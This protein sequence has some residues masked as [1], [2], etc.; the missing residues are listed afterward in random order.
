MQSNKMKN[1]I[2][3]TLLLLA[4]ALVG[5]LASAQTAIDPDDEVLD[6]QSAIFEQQESA[7]FDRLRDPIK[8][9]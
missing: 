1:C 4:V 6:R 2:Q 8:L 3:N 7:Q 9:C 5:S